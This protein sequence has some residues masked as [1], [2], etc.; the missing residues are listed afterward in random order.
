MR[1][2]TWDCLVR[3]PQTFLPRRIYDMAANGLVW[4]LSC[5]N[6][7]GRANW[8]GT[9]QIARERRGVVMRYRQGVRNQL[10]VTAE[11]QGGAPVSG[12]FKTWYK[13]TVW[14]KK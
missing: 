2:L 6:P 5:S 7:Y 1:I 4:F 9:G 8:R 13:I 10:S 11:R 3:F 14:I 12:K